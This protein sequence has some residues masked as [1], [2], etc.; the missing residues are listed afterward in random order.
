MTAAQWNGPARG[1]RWIGLAAALLVQGVAV[2]VLWMDHGWRPHGRREPPRLTEV[3]LL[4]LAAERQPAPAPRHEAR[5]PEQPPVPAPI[6]VAA[7]EVLVTAAPPTSA[8]QTVAAPAVPASAASAPPGPGP[9]PLNLALPKGGG[10]ADPRFHMADQIRN[11]PR[12]HSERRTVESAIADAAGTLPIVTSTST[13]GSGSKIV[14]QGS[15]CTRVYE[16]RVAELN[17]TD[18]RMK[19]APMLAGG[20]F[21]K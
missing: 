12:S 13:S 3:R 9:S 21:G 14:R 6:V 11:D 5:R 18:D 10:A 20:C 7:P 8:I 4:P 17:P 19:G 15:K 2:L 16:N 1:R